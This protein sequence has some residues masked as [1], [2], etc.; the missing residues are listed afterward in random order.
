MNS[1]L[2]GQ[3]RSASSR[4][5]QFKPTSGKPDS[6]EVF[7]LL[8]QEG[9]R[10]AVR[11]FAD[12]FE[13]LLECDRR[14]SLTERTDQHQHDIFLN[15][16]KHSDALLKA[17]KKLRRNDTDNTCTDVRSATLIW[18]SCSTL[19]QEKRQSFNGLPIEESLRLADHGILDLAYPTQLIRGLE[20][21]RDAVA[22]AAKKTKPKPGNSASH[23]IDT[24]R[25]D[26][27][28]NGFVA[29]YQK[30]FHKL[31][32][33]TEDGKAHQV[34]DLLVVAAKLEGT[35]NLSCLR[36]AIIKVRKHNQEWTRNG[37]E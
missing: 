32:K 28:A 18:I 6:G 1:V 13:S 5:D 22:H 23:N 27:L 12:D 11:G 25:R 30:H 37:S 3:P 34:F 17:L 15:L 14:A 29:N 4:P 7:R 9:S 35:K 20:G 33:L 26:H 31:P 16:L 19:L 24:I 2:R 10:D 36:R 21:M 8:K